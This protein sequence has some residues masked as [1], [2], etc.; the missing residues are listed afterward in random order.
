[1]TTHTAPLAWQRWNVQRV[2][3]IQASLRGSPAAPDVRQAFEQ[4][5]AQGQREAQA[6]ALAQG[7]QQGHEAGYAQ[8]LEEGMRQ[9]REQALAERC[10]QAQDEA[11][12]GLQAQ[13][14]EL[15]A[16]AS[17]LPQ[18][19]AAA[20]DTLAQ[21]LSD[22]ALSIA[23]QVVGQALGADPALMLGAVRELMQA[24]PALS[25]APQLLLHPD[26]LLLVREHLQE[27]LQS[28]GWR[29]VADAG[30]ERGGCRVLAASGELDARLGTRW[31]R[32]AAALS[33]EPVVAHVTP[34]PVA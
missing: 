15:L 2:A 4:G 32:V 1:M 16:L 5:R 10:T 14:E 28:A 19:L 22:L 6:T 33:C 34:E 17:S 30:L 25:G 11:V 13:A 7:L 9:G 31:Q 8:G 27:E 12:Q 24:E 26:D 21:S 18:A 3:P 29:L 23:R 20:E